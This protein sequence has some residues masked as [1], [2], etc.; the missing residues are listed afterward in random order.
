MQRS[1][2][3]VVRDKTRPPFK[4]SL[5]SSI[6]FFLSFWS[7]GA[8]PSLDPPRQPTQPIQLKDGNHSPCHNQLPHVPTTSLLHRIMT[9]IFSCRTLLHGAVSCFPA[10]RAALHERRR[11]QHPRGR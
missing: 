7:N 10:P 11:I 9:C 5:S 2:L 1:S 4:S 3:H 6:P 8:A